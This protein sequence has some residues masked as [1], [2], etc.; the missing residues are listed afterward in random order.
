MIV[1]I[2]AEKEKEKQD[3]KDQKS[4]ELEERKR[5][6]LNADEEKRVRMEA[7]KRKASNEFKGRL[8][9]TQI[10]NHTKLGDQNPYSPNLPLVLILFRTLYCRNLQLYQS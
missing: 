5:K 8:E 2:K 4:R 3:I 9:L 1:A 6:R 7:K 10:S